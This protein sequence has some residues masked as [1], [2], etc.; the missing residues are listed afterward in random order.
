MGKPELVA[1]NGEKS[2]QLR[3]D[4]FASIVVFLVALPLCIGIA[5][6]VGVS[7]P[8][9]LITGIIG[10][11]V[12]GSLA[13]SPLQVSGPAAGLF[14]IVAELL[15]TSKQ[16]YL[17][18]HNLSAAG[19]DAAA[20]L[21]SQAALYALT[22]LGAAVFLAGCLQLIAGRFGLGQWF[23]AVSPA[24]IKGMLAGIGALI[25]VSQFHVMLDHRPMWNGEP[26]RGGLQHLAAIP[27]AVIKA[28]SPD[29]THGHHLAAAT[30]ML[31][32]VVLMGWP[33]L[34]PKKL[35]VVPAALVAVIVATIFSLALDFSIS[36]LVVPDQ[37]FAEVTLPSQQSIALLADRAVLLAGLVIAVV[38]SAE[39]LLCATAVDQMHKGPRT[40]YD[41]E[42]MSQG[43]GNILC[44]LVGALP[45]T[46]VI[47]RSSANVQAGAKTRFSTILHGAWLLVFVALF[48][49]VLAYIPKAALGALLV[50]TGWKLLHIKEARS[51]WKFSKSEALIFV[52]T[53]VVIVV[54]DLLVGVMVGVALSAAKLLYTFT[55]LH[56]DL[57]ISNDQKKA[58]L[59][60]RGSATFLRLPNLARCLE[61][62]PSAAELH[63]DM[64]ALNYVDHACLELLMTWAKQHES[65][66]G[67]L[68]MDWD[69]LHAKF[70]QDGIT[71][72]A[73]Q[74]PALELAGRES[75]VANT[76]SSKKELLRARQA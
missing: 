74:S 44:G 33:E 42:L 53:M 70:N 43:V 22:V 49:S 12:V 66:G 29:G 11:I 41:R 48:P 2:S 51:L 62:V 72:S 71:S 35:R 13:G 10:G 30:G 45:M 65:T 25:L 63:V 34:A 8:R 28:L 5:V 23:R 26:A 27:E 9:A 73:M 24:V 1:N 50:Y 59:K 64:H 17:E 52:V 69:S 58:D 15:T 68:V 20:A 56:S 3:S 46:G 75:S 36:R 54:E 61:R 55:H 21:Q 32:I 38:A 16:R 60:L 4:F 6:A 19:S 7:P 76:D 57:V 31:T 67:S 14:V 47:V 37:F 18:S 40:N 39:T